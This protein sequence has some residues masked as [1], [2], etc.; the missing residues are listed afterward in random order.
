MTLYLAFEDLEARRIDLDEPV[1]I[2]SYAATTP[3]YR[4]GMRPAEQ[5]PLRILLEGVAIASANDAAT[6]LAEH[7]AG[8]ELNFVARMNAKGQEMGLSNTVFA[9]PHGLPDPEQRSSARDLAQLTLR[10]LR[11][12]PAARPLLGGQ[13]FIYRGR[14][15]TRHISLFRDP[16]GVQALKTGFTQEAGY[17]LAVAA[18]RDGQQFVMILLGCRSRQHSFLDAKRL[19]HFGFVETGLEPPEEERP[20]GPRR[21]VRIRRTGR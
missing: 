5:V 3:R 13:T 8:D 4:M 12:H 10:L 16:L 1:R 15:Y 21:P 7:L 20:P 19:L 9:N 17:S 11:D 6:A 14:V 18:W 2:S